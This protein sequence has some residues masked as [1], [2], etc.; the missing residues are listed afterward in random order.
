MSLR[1]QA[2]EVLLGNWRGHNTIP[3][4]G[5]YPHQWSWDSAFIAVGLRHLS[6]LRAQQELESLFGAQWADGR[7][8]H[9]VFDPEAPRQG[10]FPGPEFWRSEEVN[11]PQHPDTSGIVQP[12]VHALAAWE[13]HAS[14]PET[15]RRRSFLERLYPKL[16]AWHDY[17]RGRRD[18]GGRGLVSIVHPWES[19]MDNSPSWDAPLQRVEPVPPTEFQRRDLDHA[20]ASER[21][22]DA[23]YGRYVRLAAT[24]RDHGY[25]DGLQV[26]E[27]AVEDPVTNSLLAASEA[28]LVRIAQELGEP[29]HPHEAEVAR[30]RDA[31]PLLLEDGLFHSYDVHGGDLVRGGSVA[32]LVPLVVPGLPQ[33]QDLIATATGP[34]FRAE[35]LGVVP[36]WDLT[37]PL[38]DPSRYW[39]GP[40]WF[41]ITWLL[42]RGLD[43]HGAPELAQVLRTGMLTAANRSGFREYIDPR[44]C[45]GKG[46]HHFSWTAAVVLDLLATS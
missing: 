28:A 7:V 5:L 23:D 26:H 46:A 20:D 21:P 6:S 31:L 22:T 32:G 30:I 37:D 36:S 40:A 9:I 34:R 44:T 39:R 15:S 2:A 17:L 33:A 11:G 18:L 35:E 41:N 10:Y 16:V 4:P 38:F 27:F 43:D 8:P 25:A 45:E 1:D 42:Q 19:G 13:V 3:A 24:Y 12:P 14:D 29:A